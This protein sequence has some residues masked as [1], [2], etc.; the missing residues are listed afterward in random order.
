MTL[1]IFDTMQGKKREFSPLIPNQV[2]MYVCGITPYAHSHLGHARC[3]VAF[4]I[5]GM[6]TIIGIHQGKWSC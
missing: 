1:A 5:T 2:S 6:S 3:Y 4:V